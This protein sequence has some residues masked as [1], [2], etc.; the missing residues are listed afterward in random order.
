MSGLQTAWPSSR[1]CL[2]PSGDWIG[3]GGLVMDIDV[4]ILLL[5]ICLVFITLGVWP[6]RALFPAAEARVET[7][8]APDLVEQAAAKK[9]TPSGCAGQR[10]VP[11]AQGQLAG[12]ATALAGAA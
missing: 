6:I 7:R 11:R 5:T 12:E 8:S 2:N 3:K 1:A 10:P 9:P 4:W